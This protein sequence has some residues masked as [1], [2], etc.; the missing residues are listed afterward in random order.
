M[1]TTFFALICLLVLSPA[2]KAGYAQG[3]KPA[4]VSGAWALQI[5]IPGGGTATPTVTFKQDGE[6]LT[7]VY[8]SQVLGEQQV[9]GTI[10]GNDIMFGFQ[11]TMDGNTFKVTYKGTVDKDTMKGTANF[12]DMGEGAFTAKKK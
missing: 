1:K 4:D 6:K 2:V 10:K 7:G 12:G 11:A 9:T 5:E 3:D 8:S